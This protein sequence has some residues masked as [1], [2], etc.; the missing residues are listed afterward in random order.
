MLNIVFD[1][2]TGPL[3]DDQLEKVK[4]EFKAPGNLKDP[5]KIEAAI[6]E[7]EQ[8]WRDN[9]ALSAVTGHV[10]AIGYTNERGGIATIVVGDNIEQADGSFKTVDECL[11]LQGFWGSFQARQQTSVRFVGFNIFGFDLPFM[12]RRSWMLGIPV[13]YN[14]RKGRYWSERFVDLRESW[15]LGDRM[16]SGSLDVIAR[17]FGVGEKNGSGAD[18]A[19]TLKVDRHAAAAYL[20]NDVNLTR[21]VDQRMNPEAYQ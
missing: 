13:P 8:E 6:R 11:L 14:V 2:E 7:K 21:L 19:K 15:Q 5:A 3:P 17:A 16:A 10:L 18:F 9:A 12:I 1:I 4:P 20:E